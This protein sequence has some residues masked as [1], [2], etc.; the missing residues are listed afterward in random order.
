MVHI[1]VDISLHLCYT[2]LMYI[3]PSYKKAGAKTYTYYNLVEGVRTSKGPRHRVI[4]SLGKLENV[5]EER[6]KLLGRLIDQKLRGQIRLLPPEAEEEELKAEAERVV[7][8]VVRKNAVERADEELVCVKLDQME[9]GLAVLL[10]PVYVG[11]QMWKRLGLEETLRDCGLSKRQRNLAMVEV[12]GRL[13]EARSELA[14]SGWVDRTGLSDLVGEKLDYVNKDSLYRVSDRL[15]ALREKIESALGGSE[16]GLFEL[17]ETM[18]LY[19]LTSTYF[20]GLAFSNPK[21]QLGYSR[22]RRGDCKQLVV[23]MVLDEAGFP[24]ATE[25]WKGNTHDSSTLEAMLQQLEARSGKRPGSTVVMDRGIATAH[26]VEFLKQWGY[27][28]IVTLSGQSRYEWIDEIRG[29]EFRQLDIHH[30]DIEVCEREREGEVYLLVRSQP[31]IGKDKAIRERF[32]E[33]LQE[34]LRKM[35]PQVASGKLTRDKAWGKIGR[36]RQRYQR[37]SRF[38]RV[39]IEGQEGKLDLHWSI[40]E[41]KLAE[42]EILDGVYILK[43]DRADL[44]YEKLWGLYM[45]LERVERSFRYLKSSLGIRPI[46]HHLQKR[47][48]GHIFI[49]VLAY[50]LLHTIEQLLLAHDDHRSWPTI[51]DELETHRALTA[52]VPDGIG[53]VHHIRVATRATE[54]QKKI[55]RMLGLSTKPLRTKRYVVEAESSDENQ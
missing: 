36:L 4:L 53:R 30:P 12:V 15:W 13:V 43:T 51:N 55:Y 33:R 9:A 46:F 38:F 49:S 11:L 25:T 7:S 5:P 44:D 10:G 17:E 42:A 22:D 39:E 18:V 27:H 52:E 6:I 3:V 35:A 2:P 26:N 37:A 31:R 29:A 28:Y 48:D 20:E 8:V 14:T 21:A 34:A 50:H 54:E 32:C 24:K 45:M 47:S 23:G 41:K 16:R 1:Y 40:D 19:D